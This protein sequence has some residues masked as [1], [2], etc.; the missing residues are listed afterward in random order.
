MSIEARTTGL[1]LGAIRIGL[2]LAAVLGSTAVA[3]DLKIGFTLSLTGGTDDYGKGAR[4]GAELALK[5]YND[6]GGYQS[7]KV[8]AVIYDD[9]TKPANRVGWPEAPHRVLRSAIEA[10]EALQD[11]SIG[12][13]TNIDG[14]HAAVPRFAATV[15]D[16]STTGHVGSDQ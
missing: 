16:R 11:N 2:L 5:E 6:K 3:A 13:V 7:K 1:R 4:M 15:A 14:T 12:T 10:A 9:E 8:E